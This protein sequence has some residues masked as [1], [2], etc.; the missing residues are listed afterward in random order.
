MITR[1][2]LFEKPARMDTL[3]TSNRTLD[4]SYKQNFFTFEFAALNFLFPEKNRYM[5]KMENLNEDWIYAGDRRYATYTNIDPGTYTFRVKACN[6]DGVWNDEGISILITIRPPFYSTWWFRALAAIAITL[7]IFLY[8]RLRTN[9][10]MKQNVILEDKV[11]QRTQEL[12]EKNVELTKTMDD[13]RATQDQLVQ[14]EKMASLG[15]LTA[16]IAH[17]IQNR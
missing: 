11:T 6:N 3:I 17:E 8:I 4:L 10:L 15:Q 13:L 12:Q 7:I 1:F 16:G 5:Y 9:A 2:Y 14:S